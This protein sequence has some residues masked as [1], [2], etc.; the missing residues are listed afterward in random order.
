MIIDLGAEVLRIRGVVDR[1]DRNSSGQLRVIDYKS[2]S[3][4]LTA[5][6]LKDGHRLQLPIYALAVRDARKLG[7]PVEGIYWKIL[8]A[9]AGSLKLSKFKTDTN[10]GVDA[11][12]EVMM[13]HLVRIVN[14][15]RS[16]E[17]P[18]KTPHVG[19]PSYCPGA[20]WC[21]RFEPEY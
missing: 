21:W 19:C 15:I 12:I 9:E 8:G 10:Q 4:H 17:F 5:N 11:A 13:A 1:V 3:M 2:G 18:S 20:Q 7:I 16:A 14:G 6:D